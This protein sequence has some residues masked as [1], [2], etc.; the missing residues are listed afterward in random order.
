MI[1]TVL[2]QR[3]QLAPLMRVISI[4]P[5]LKFDLSNN[6]PMYIV[7]KLAAARSSTVSGVAVG[8]EPITVVA[9]T[10]ELVVKFGLVVELVVEFGLVVELVVK[11]GLVVGLVPAG[12]ELVPF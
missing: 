7:V 4:T 12:L 2:D 6:L 1:V 10:R 8:F 5:S 9:L 11:F 3:G